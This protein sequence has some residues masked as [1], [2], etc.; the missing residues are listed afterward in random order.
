MNALDKEVRVFSAQS[1]SV[2]W[3][4]YSELVENRVPFK[5]RGWPVAELQWSMAKRARQSLAIPFNDESMLMQYA[6][7]EA[8]EYRHAIADG[9][10]FTLRSDAETC[11][12]LQDKLFREIVAWSREL[13]LQRLPAAEV[14]RLSRALPRFQRLEVL[15]L[16]QSQLAGED[17]QAAHHRDSSGVGTNLSLAHGTTLAGS[18]FARAIVSIRFM[19]LTQGSSQDVGIPLVIQYAPCYIP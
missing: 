18:V 6:P 19:R 12:H 7:M 1:D 15:D 16:D 13:S 5:L 11:Y 9:L 3:V 4:R 14:G 10:C 17:A 8:A 2:Q